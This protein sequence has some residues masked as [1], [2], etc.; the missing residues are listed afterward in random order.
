[1]IV[2]ALFNLAYAVLFGMI[3]AAI[4]FAY[5]YGRRGVI[6]AILTGAQ[7]KSRV[8]RTYVTAAEMVSHSCKA[9]PSSSTQF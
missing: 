4:L 8:V 9:P 2:T 3:M 6:K 7:H 1:M 5:E